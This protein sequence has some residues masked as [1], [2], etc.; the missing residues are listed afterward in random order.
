MK[1][2]TELKKQNKQLKESLICE[3]CGGG[4]QNGGETGPGNKTLGNEGLPKVPE[5]YT[6]L[7]HREKITKLQIHP[8]F[9]IVATASQDGTIKLW[10]YEQ[11]EVE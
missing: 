10:D 5:K 7:G 11:G 4:G 1:E 9:T 3:K 6:L 8:S 2:N